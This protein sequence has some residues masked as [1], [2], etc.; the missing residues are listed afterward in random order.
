MGIL[1]FNL[2]SGVMSSLEYWVLAPV[3]DVNKPLDET[4]MKRYRKIAR[5]I[6]A[7]EMLAGGVMYAMGFQT[8]SLTIFLSMTMVTLMLAVGKY[9]RY[10]FRDV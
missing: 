5:I 1:H 4:E 6:W 8:V 9:K 2:I 7:M 3:A 10:R